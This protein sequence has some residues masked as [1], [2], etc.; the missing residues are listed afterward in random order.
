MSASE[1]ELHGVHDCPSCGAPNDTLV[2]PDRCRRCGH[3]WG[4]D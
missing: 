4:D 2:N 1:G 3:E